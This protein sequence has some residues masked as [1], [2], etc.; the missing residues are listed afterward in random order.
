M[1]NVYLL[2]Y[3]PAGVDREALLKALSERPVIANWQASQPSNLLTLVTD[4][5]VNDVRDLLKGLAGLTLYVL[6]RADPARFNSEISGWLP[7]ATWEFI[8]ANGTPTPTVTPPATANRVV[9][10]VA[11]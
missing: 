8:V 11:S 7:T 5:P 2:T 9:Q 10:A 6:I 3:E 4:L 1:N